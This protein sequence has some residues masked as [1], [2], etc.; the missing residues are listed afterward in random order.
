MISWRVYCKNI[1]QALSME[2]R[3]KYVGSVYAFVNNSKI[4]N[5]YT[6]NTDG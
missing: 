5:I 1:I 2:C 3:R 4:S 6:F